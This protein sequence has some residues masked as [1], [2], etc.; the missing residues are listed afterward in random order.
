MHKTMPKRKPDDPE[1]PA[2]TESMIPKKTKKTSVVVRDGEST[3]CAQTLLIL[4]GCGRGQ[5]SKCRQSEPKAPHVR[6]CICT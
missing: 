6:H 5:L 2:K 4:A 1:S 3:L